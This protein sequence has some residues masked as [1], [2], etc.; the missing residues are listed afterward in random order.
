[1]VIK[2]SEIKGIFFNDLE[3]VRRYGIWD[4]RL[5]CISLIPIIILAVLAM[6]QIFSNK[7]ISAVFVLFM[8][9]TILIYPLL[10]FECNLLKSWY[11]RKKVLETYKCMRHDCRDCTGSCIYVEEYGVSICIYLDHEFKK[12]IDKLIEVSKINK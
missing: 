4:M 12:E 5:F 6:A 1:M 8:I 7:Y 3:K 2:M 9:F 10:A 11:R